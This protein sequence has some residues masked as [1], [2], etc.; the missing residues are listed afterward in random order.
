ME[1]EASAFS[2]VIGGSWAPGIRLPLPASLTGRHFTISLSHEKTDNRFS[3]QGFSHF[4]AP[5]DLWPM[6]K[7]KLQLRRCGRS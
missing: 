7:S 5:R 4:S 6:S 1:G 3:S 2:D